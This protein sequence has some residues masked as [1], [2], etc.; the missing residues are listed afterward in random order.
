MF[1][2]TDAPLKMYALLALVSRTPVIASWVENRLLA[3]VRFLNLVQFQIYPPPFIVL[4]VPDWLNVKILYF[5]IGPNVK[6][7]EYFNSI[8]SHLCNVVSSVVNCANSFTSHAGFPQCVRVWLIWYIS[9]HD[10][11]CQELSQFAML[12]VPKKKFPEPLISTMTNSE[13][14]NSLF[15]P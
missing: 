1:A 11:I 15:P 5:L 6:N 4:T 2:C 12:V 3:S 10:L 9:Q 14:V 13:P 7:F 8:G